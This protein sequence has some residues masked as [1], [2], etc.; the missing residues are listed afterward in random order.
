MGP[1]TSS[2]TS[3]PTF[4]PSEQPTF[5][6]AICGT[7]AEHASITLPPTTTTSPTTSPSTTS[8]PT[9]APLTNT[10]AGQTASP[11]PAPTC[12]DGSGLSGAVWLLIGLLIA[13]VV[14]LIVLLV[15]WYQKRQRMVRE[16]SEDIGTQVI[17][18]YDHSHEQEVSEEK[19]SDRDS[20]TASTGSW[21]ESPPAQ[22]K[23]EDPAK[24]KVIR[25]HQNRFEDHE[26]IELSP[27]T[28]QSLLTQ[29]RIQQ[30]KIDKD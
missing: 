20:F 1:T 17:N 9:T 28:I 14:A 21:T 30:S 22:L 24:M 15:L 16:P 18:V 2:P 6:T 12:G 4:S 29:C 7:P 26:A 8:P 19:Q 13:C 5:C 23:I 11:T 3:S 25:M 27:D 10:T